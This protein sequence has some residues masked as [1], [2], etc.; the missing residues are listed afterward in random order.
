MHQQFVTCDDR[1]GRAGHLTGKRLALRNLPQLLAGD[2]VNRQQKVINIITAVEN[3]PVPDNRGRGRIAAERPGQRHLPLPEFFPFQVEADQAKRTE[4]GDHPLAIGRRRTAGRIKRCVPFF[5]PLCR[6]NSFPPDL[7]A[8]PGDADNRELL[9]ALIIGRQKDN[10]A[11]NNRGAVTCPHRYVPEF[12][13]PGTKFN[14]RRGAWSYT[15]GVGPSKLL[16]VGGP[17]SCHEE[18]DARGKDPRLQIKQHRNPLHCTIRKPGARNPLEQA[19]STE[20]RYYTPL[21]PS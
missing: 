16:P 3:N 9:P 18:Q 17:G 7:T 15:R 11:N 2:L 20:G 12:I 14:G 13:F 21:R 1:T 5:D 4:V 19:T 10:F 6:H 8:G